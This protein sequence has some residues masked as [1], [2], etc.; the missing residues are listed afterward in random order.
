[1]RS[2][3]RAPPRSVAWLEGKRARRDRARRTRPPT[4]KL[5]H[6]TRGRIG[7]SRGGCG[8]RETRRR[9][10]DRPSRKDRDGR[11]ALAYCVL[12]GE[13]QSGIGSGGLGLG[14][15]LED[16]DGD[17]AVGLLLVLAEARHQ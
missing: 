12:T 5:V 14:D 6:A 8:R 1:M 7:A 3:S 17:R 10:V 16:N 15:A 13:L 11:L 4:A 9:R 2:E